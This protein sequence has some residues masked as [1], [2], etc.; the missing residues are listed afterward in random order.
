LHGLLAS[1]A[2]LVVKPSAVRHVFSAAAL[3]FALGTVACDAT[4]G[5]DVEEEIV[6]E[7]GSLDS[8]GTVYET[9]PWEGPYL[10]FPTGRRY[11]LVHDLGRRPLLVQ[12]YVAFEERPMPANSE[13]RASDHT[14]IA[15]SA[16][17]QVVIEIVNDQMI[18]VRNDTC[19][20]LYLRVVAIAPAEGDVAGVSPG[21][22]H[23]A[24]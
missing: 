17:N 1:T 12:T 14:N 8:S 7:G 9:S 13:P 11:A 4:C 24:R 23:E 21:A 15:E 3:A 6:F 16:G 18:G 19:A 2:T 10:H 5:R 20:E 22:P